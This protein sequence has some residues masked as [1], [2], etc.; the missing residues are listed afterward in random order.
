MAA[1][2]VE[3][4]ERDA[5]AALLRLAG[6][7]VLVRDMARL[8]GIAEPVCA[9]RLKLRVKAQEDANRARSDGESE[10]MPSGGGSGVD[11]AG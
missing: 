10:G 9:R 1:A 7:K 4:A 5:T 8:T 2:Q 6:E 11:A 3:A